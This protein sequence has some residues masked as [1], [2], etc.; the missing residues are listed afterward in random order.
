MGG[1]VKD[2]GGQFL[3]PG[4]SPGSGGGRGVAG[5]PPSVSLVPDP[6]QVHGEGLEDS[7]PL[8]GAGEEEEEAAELEEGQGSGGCSPAGLRG[9]THGRGSPKGSGEGAS[10]GAGPLGQRLRPRGAVPTSSQSPSTPGPLKTAKPGGS[11]RRPAGLRGRGTQAPGSRVAGGG[12]GGG[13]GSGGS[14]RLG[15]GLCGVPGCG[16]QGL[17]SGEGPGAGCEGESKPESSTFSGEEEEKGE[18]EEVRT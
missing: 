6:W 17:E 15:R 1:R 11:G 8:G 13:R 4:H 5:V 7:P 18:E 9:L 16:V 10:Q 14:P 12:G 3:H 2:N